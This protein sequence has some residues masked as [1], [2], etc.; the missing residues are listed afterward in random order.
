[1]KTENI[2]FID[3]VRRKR[4]S[5]WGFLGCPYYES[6]KIS[7]KEKVYTFRYCMERF[8]ETTKGEMDWSLRMM[9]I[10]FAKYKELTE[11]FGIDFREFNNR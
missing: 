9:E 6:E 11:Q 2:L 10:N 1:M 5:F 8:G 4:K 7:F 3:R